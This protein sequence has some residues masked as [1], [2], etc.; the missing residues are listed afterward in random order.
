LPL[1]DGPDAFDRLLKAEENLL[2]I[3]LEP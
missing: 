1:E 3:V 2:K